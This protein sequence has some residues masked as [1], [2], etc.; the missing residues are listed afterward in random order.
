MIK[1]IIKNTYDHF[2][3]KEVDNSNKPIPCKSCGA[4]CAYF[5]VEFNKKKNP[6]VPE[7]KIHFHRG[8]YT[9]KGAEKFKQRCNN[10]AGTIGKDVSCDIYENR[11]DVCKLFDVWLPNGKQNPRCKTARIYHGLPGEI[12]LD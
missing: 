10:L 1:D 6:Q 5:K 12:P 2:F 8:S 7:E 11:P 4:C 9:L 3:G